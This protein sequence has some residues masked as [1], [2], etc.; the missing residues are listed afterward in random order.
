[1]TI[2][3]IKYHNLNH[4]DKP[5]AWG[6]VSDVSSNLKD[7]LEAIGIAYEDCALAMPMWEGA[8]EIVHNYAL[9]KNGTLD[10]AT[11]VNKGALFDDDSE[12]L[13]TGIT[14]TD[15]LRQPGNLNDCTFL[16]GYRKT[17][18]PASLHYFVCLDPYQT[19]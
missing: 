7:R 12:H 4:A 8:G 1:M 13:N 17:A 19:K 16:I 5:S 2:L 11:F 14:V 3:P 6:N 10:G 9:P 15:L 18:T